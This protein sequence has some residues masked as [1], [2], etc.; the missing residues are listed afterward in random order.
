MRIYTQVSEVLWDE[1]PL[2]YTAA[3]TL[4]GLWLCCF[5]LKL[6]V[7][8]EII[9]CLHLFPEKRTTT[10]GG[11]PSIPPVLLTRRESSL[12]LRQRL[13]DKNCDL[14]RE[15][16]KKNVNNGETRRLSLSPDMDTTAT[17]PSD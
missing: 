1:W 12:K 17:E 11:F 5:R 16:S 15:D 9:I 2:H 10:C 8:W 7:P 13:E 3:V 6:H 14:E 4:R